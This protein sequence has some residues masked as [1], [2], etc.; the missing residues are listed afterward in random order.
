MEGEGVDAEAGAELK[1][2]FTE[3]W[4]DK[5]TDQTIS[6]AAVRAMFGLP[7]ASVLE[8]PDPEEHGR[9]LLHRAAHAGRP[10]LCKAL[11]ELGVD[12]K[13]TDADGK[14]ALDLAYEEDHSESVSVLAKADIIAPKLREL[15]ARCAEGSIPTEEA[16]AFLGW[17][18]DA[19]GKSLA[20][21]EEAE[22]VR[23]LAS[24]HTHHLCRLWDAR[25]S[26]HATMQLAL[27]H[28]GWVSAVRWLG[29]GVE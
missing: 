23:L 4:G 27:Q 10:N 19:D 18:I 2:R 22:F 25:C 29:P 14:T 21:E 24:G 28:K 26:P 20:P 16:Q 5:P 7:P 11:L 8:L 13:L 15:E 6:L 3:S 9:S 12:P 17:L 1:Q